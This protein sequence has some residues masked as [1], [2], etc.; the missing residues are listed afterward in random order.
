MSKL[1][2]KW[3]FGQE[4]A[5]VVRSKPALV[6]D[7]LIIGSQFGE[8]YALNK[9]TGKI[10]WKFTAS[11]A[12]RGGI[13]IIKKEND[14]TVIFAD[15]G[16]SVYALNLATGK[17]KWSARAGFEPLSAVTGTVVAYNNKIFVPLSTVEISAVANNSYECC[18]S[19]GGIVALDAN[20]GKVVWK[21]RNTAP[22]KFI[23]KNKKGKEFYGPSGAPVWCSPTVD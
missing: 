21:Y 2:L 22:A 12:I 9:N 4:D 1:K 8:V 18:K 11:N 23:G 15:Y 14:Y 5:V 17:L 3:A 6:G 10:G 16:T 13:H 20:T 7:W 19:S